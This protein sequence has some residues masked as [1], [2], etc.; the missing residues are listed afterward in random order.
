MARVPTTPIHFDHKD[1]LVAIEAD[2]GQDDG[3][4]F[5]PVR[6]WDL[7]A[8]WLEADE[9]ELPY[10]ERHMGAKPAKQLNKRTS[11]TAKVALT[12]HGGR[13]DGMPLWDP[14]VRAAGAVRTVIAATPHGTIGAGPVRT[15]GTGAFTYARTAAFTGLTDRTVTLTC[16]TAGGSG[17][18][19]FTVAAPALPGVVA[20][21]R[22]GQ[23]MTDATPFALADGAVVTPAVTTPFVAGD[24]FQIALS[25]AGTL[26]QPSSDRAG[27]KSAAFRMLLPDPAGGK[28][29]LYRLLGARLNVKISGQ[30]G[31]YP[32]LDVSV[33][34]LFT[35]PALRDATAAVDY[36]DWPDPI[37][38]STEHT[39]ACSLFGHDL[40]VETFGI[41]FGNAVEYKPRVGRAAVRIN[42][43]KSTGSLK[44]EEP[45]LGD[46][47]ILAA[48]ANG[49]TGVF[50][51]QH[52]TAP[53]EI[54]RIEAPR[55]QIG[56]PTWSD[57]SK[58][59][60]VETPLKL[61]PV[62]GDD[63]WRLFIPA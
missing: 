38:V 34:S 40:V 3:L 30:I 4:V 17:V 57:S 32:V 53:G 11:F 19:A 51:I 50:A 21:D 16:T 13:A 47:N 60:M 62:L 15:V 24:T 41:D 7:S 54:V 1:I 46:F 59:L 29:R 2:Y 27:H 18:A 35:E 58:D 31:D 48:A 44:F 39:P 36:S 12:G 25:A 10:V 26:Y 33:T 49:D 9:K 6:L 20:V 56:K 55:V 43:R 28:E 52:G 37:E 42:D 5:L 63:E 8:T 61:L 23:V 14:I 22:A 45:G